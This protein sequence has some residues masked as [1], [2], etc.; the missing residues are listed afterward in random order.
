MK[1]IAIFQRDLTIGGIQKS[2]VNL[3]N[4]INYKKYNVDLYLFGKG[5]F[6]N[7]L[8]DKV[9]VIM[10]EDETKFVKIRNFDS[11]YKKV[12]LN[13]LD[14]EYDISIDFNGY[15][16]LTSIG[17]LKANAKKKV[18]WIHN[19]INIKYGEEFKFKVIFNT[20][21]SK[22]KYFDEVVCVS[23]GVKEAFNIMTKLITNYKVIPNYI[24]TKEILEKADEPID[25][26][27]DEDKL[28]LVCLGRLVHQKGYDLLMPIIKELSTIRTDFHLYMIGDGPDEEDLKKQ[29]NDLGI[30]E[31]V[32]FMGSKKNPYPYLKLM[33]AL[34]FNS[35]YEGQ[36]MVLL[37]GACLGLQIVMPHHLE[38][39]C[40]GIEGVDSVLST[41]R[42]LEKVDKKIDKLNKYNKEI[43]KNLE[44]LFG[45]VDE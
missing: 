32:T 9:N 23:T 34:V 20:S 7:Q 39:Y 31:Y 30:S 42:R 43:T 35:R 40:D 38:K 37:E 1:Q 10:L 15:D 36:G 44:E 21:K 18:V 45:E 13:I 33:D 27:V 2:L 22:Y 5:E 29:V 3:L 6:F 11:L 16:K 19:D 25:F 4:N 8:P 12:N 26:K 28:N 41:L 24:N 14:K 17:A